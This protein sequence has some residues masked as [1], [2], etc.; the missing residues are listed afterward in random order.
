METQVHLSVC[1]R[2]RPP[3]FTGRLKERPGYK[4]AEAVL[5]RIREEAVPGL[6]LRGVECMSQCKRPCAVALSAHGKFTLIFGDQEQDVDA[7]LALAR[8]YAESEEGLVPRTDRPQPLRESILGRVPPLDY[9][10]EMLD[11]TFSL[12]RSG[13]TL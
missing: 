13:D 10:G 3:D 2:C 6:T 4:L 5:A 11:P 1:T 12:T 9:A 8:Q 7:I